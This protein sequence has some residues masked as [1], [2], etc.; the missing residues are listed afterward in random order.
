MI[1]L[2]RYIDPLEAHRGQLSIL[3]ARCLNNMNEPNNPSPLC[4]KLSW[5][6]QGNLCDN[7][8]RPSSAYSFEPA[9][10]IADCINDY[11]ALIQ[12]ATTPEE[13]ARSDRAPKWYEAVY[14]TMVWAES[15]LPD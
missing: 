11:D 15:S 12:E 6:A 3:P 1:A 5:V 4:R 14:G 8:L 13:K 10:E 7:S 2:I 9:F